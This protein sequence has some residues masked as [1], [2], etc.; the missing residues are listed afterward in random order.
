MIF[1]WFS[2][3]VWFWG[4][5]GS[6]WVSQRSSLTEFKLMYWAFVWNWFAPSG[7]DPKV[8]WNNFSTSL[9][10]GV[11]PA[12]QRTCACPCKSDFLRVN[13]HWFLDFRECF[14][15]KLSCDICLGEQLV[16]KMAPILNAQIQKNHRQSI[17]KNVRRQQRQ[18]HPRSLRH[19]L[20]TFAASVSSK[21][22]VFTL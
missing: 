11:R 6:F 22:T 3:S 19:S 5:F 2:W 7:I 15:R 20:G 13:I 21:N 1:L 16:H 14:I 18:T 9:D 8:I 12:G 10:E 4:I 17:P